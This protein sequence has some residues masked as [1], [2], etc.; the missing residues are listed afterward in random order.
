MR[1]PISLALAA[2]LCGAAA[3]PAAAD[4]VT[5]SYAASDLATDSGAQA[6]YDRLSARAARLCRV[7]DGIFKSVE[8]T[9][10]ESLKHDWVV[11]INDARVE[12]LHR[13][14]CAH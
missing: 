6:V 11:A 3:S 1:I 8:T 5:F 10:T 12:E 9:C 4:Y 13:R 14:E 7:P 2:G